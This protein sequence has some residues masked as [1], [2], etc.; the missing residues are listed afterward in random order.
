MWYWQNGPVRSNSLQVQH[1]HCVFATHDRTR[2]RLKVI[3]IILLP[4]TINNKA[5][6]ERLCE[7]VNVEEKSET[8][9]E[10]TT[11]DEIKKISPILLFTSRLCTYNI[12]VRINLLRPSLLMTA[13]PRVVSLSFDFQ[14]LRIALA[15]RSLPNEK[16]IVWAWMLRRSAV[17]Q[18]L[19]RC[20]RAHARY[21]CRWLC[22]WV[23]S[24]FSR[25]KLHRNFQR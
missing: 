12:I 16:L 17:L 3:H 9:N 23:S 22:S 7:R 25:Q 11:S 14:I 19:K 10:E 13:F 20:A 8:N 4:K 24:Q 21:H 2:P 18:G 1:R 6:W 15:L 5:K